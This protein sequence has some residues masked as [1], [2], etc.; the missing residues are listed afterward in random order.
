MENLLINILKSWG[1]VGRSCLMSGQKD[2]DL[3]WMIRFSFTCPSH[4][5]L[6]RLQSTNY[7]YFLGYCFLEWASN[8]CFCKGFTNS[9]VRTIW[10]YIQFPC[11]W[12]QRKALLLPPSH[13]SFTVVL[14]D[15]LINIARVSGVFILLA[16][17]VFLLT[18][19][20]I[21]SLVQTDSRESMIII[22]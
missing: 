2:Q 9:E 17:I 13:L 1:I 5:I 11:N 10:K 14:H 16:S 12:M 20:M 4:L 15:D 22:S 8:I 18:C 7:K 3:I 19:V 21:V 6:T